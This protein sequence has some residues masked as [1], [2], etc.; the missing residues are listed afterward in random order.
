MNIK[1]ILCSA[2]A[3]AIVSFFAP[4]AEGQAHRPFRLSRF[5]QKNFP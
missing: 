5:L 2:A 1:V 4:G 3:A